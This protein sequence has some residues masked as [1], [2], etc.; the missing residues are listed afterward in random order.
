MV[1]QIRVVAQFPVH[2]LARIPRPDNEQSFKFALFAGQEGK[3]KSPIG[4]ARLGK[5]DA[6]DQARSPDEENRQSSIDDE[7][8]AGVTPKLMDKQDG[9]DDPRGTDKGRL[10]EVEKVGDTRISPHPFVKTEEEEA[11]QLKRNDKPYRI[12]KGIDI[13]VR[14][15]PLKTYE[16]RK[17]IREI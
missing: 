2:F 12:V 8:A 10:D 4:R 15:I 7:D 1:I 3:G 16:V 17:I 11:A 9:Q 6:D 5:E 14:D 13:G